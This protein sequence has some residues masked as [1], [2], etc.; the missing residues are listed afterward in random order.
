MWPERAGFCPRQ[1]HQNPKEGIPPTEGVKGHKPGRDDRGH[2]VRVSQVKVSHSVFKCHNFHF[3]ARP[4]PGDPGF[5][6]WESVP[7]PDS[8]A[9]CHLLPTRGKPAPR[10]GLRLWAPSQALGVLGLGR[11]LSQ[12]AWGLGSG[13]SAPLLPDGRYGKVQRRCRAA[14]HGH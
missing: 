1:L 3:R 4:L 5:R 9:G 14:E 10:P 13:G 7:R 2:F 8:E 6:P 11:V 12:R